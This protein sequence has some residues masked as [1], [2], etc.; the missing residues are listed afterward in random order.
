MDKMDEEK[1]IMEKRSSFRGWK[2]RNKGNTYQK[3]N[4]IIAISISFIL[5]MI[6]FLNKNNDSISIEENMTSIEQQNNTPSPTPIK[7]SSLTPTPSPTPVKTPSPT[8]KKIAVGKIG[9]PL[10]DNGF[11]ITVERVTPLSLYTSIWISVRNLENKEQ[12]FKIGSGTI[13]IDSKEQQ[14]ESIKVARS[15][16]ISQTNLYAKAM[17][18]GAIF[19]ERLKEGRTLKKLVL[20]INGEKTEFILS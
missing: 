6:P 3:R 16:E 5:I 9:S 2:E 20:E 13:V 17:R 18:E 7:T 19:F 12:Q 10:V 8:P 4:I 14:Y 11:E 15:G 1:K